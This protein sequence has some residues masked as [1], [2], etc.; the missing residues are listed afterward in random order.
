MGIGGSTRARWKAFG[1]AYK[2]RETRDKQLLGM[3]P[4]RGWRHRYTSFLF[5]AHGSVDWAAAHSYVAIDFYGAMG[6]DQQSFTLVWG[7]TRSCPGP[8]STAACPEFHIGCRQG[9]S[10]FNSLPDS[11]PGRN[12]N[13]GE[14]LDQVCWNQG[15]LCRK[16][17]HFLLKIT[18][19]HS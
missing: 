10:Y 4:E 12:T 6:C 15:R 18:V 13:I 1:I 11:L 3:D 8:Y 5:E 7:D 17:E 9:M 16:I 19:F 2:R 14:R